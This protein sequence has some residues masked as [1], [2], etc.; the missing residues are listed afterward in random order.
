[1]MMEGTVYAAVKEKYQFQP[2]MNSTSQANNL[3]ARCTGTVV[4]QML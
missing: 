2:A 4:R 3:L 1:M